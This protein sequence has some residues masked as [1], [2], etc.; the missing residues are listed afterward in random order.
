MNRSDF[1]LLRKL[2]D[3]EVEADIEFVNVR[4]SPPQLVCFDGAAVL[5]S[6]GYEI[7]VSG[8]HN[9]RTK[10]TTYYFCVGGAGMVC[11]VCVNGAVHGD[12]GRTHKHELMNE[13]DPWDDLPYAVSRPDLRDKTPRQIW[14]VICRQAGIRHTGCFIDP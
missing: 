10:R 9:R 11:R 13:S 3:K 12:A 7:T 14:D 2:P 8:Q 1:E 6:L 5:N 4:K